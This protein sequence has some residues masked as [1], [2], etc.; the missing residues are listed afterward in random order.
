MNILNVLHWIMTAYSFYL[1][2]QISKIIAQHIY[3][4]NN[5]ETNE[6]L[7]KHRESQRNEN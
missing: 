5:K 7:N 1:I 6:L 3:Y 2:H 4:C